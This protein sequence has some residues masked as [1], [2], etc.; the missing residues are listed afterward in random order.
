MPGWQT[1]PRDRSTRRWRR[2]SLSLRPAPGL[3]GHLS[4]AGL[5]SVMD[6]FQVAIVSLSY[7]LVTAYLFPVVFVSAGVASHLKL[8]CYSRTKQITTVETALSAA[9]Y[10]G[11]Q[12]LVQTLEEIIEKNLKKNEENRKILVFIVNFSKHLS[13]SGRKCEGEVTVNHC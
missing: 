3:P 4:Q 11:L 6:S 10:F 13:F 2:R 9:N 1:C 12:P 7:I 5:H 8:Y